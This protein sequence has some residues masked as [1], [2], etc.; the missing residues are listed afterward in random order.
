M[1]FEGEIV[2]AEGEEI[3]GRISVW[4]HPVLIMTAWKDI[5]VLSEHIKDLLNLVA[6]N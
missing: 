6:K 1:L 5:A 4:L 2:L 3:R